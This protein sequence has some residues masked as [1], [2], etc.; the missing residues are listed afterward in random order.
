MAA[1]DQA[2]STAHAQLLQAREE[3]A[4]PPARS[5]QDALLEALRRPYEASALV[6]SSNNSSN[7]SRETSWRRSDLRV[8][9]GRFFP[10]YTQQ[11]AAFAALCAS[12][13]RKDAKAATDRRKESEEQEDEALVTVSF[14][15]LKRVLVR[16]YGSTRLVAKDPFP[17]EPRVEPKPERRASIAPYVPGPT[18]GGTDNGSDDMSAAVLRE[19]QAEVLKKSKS[20]LGRWRARHLLLR[21]G[22]L[23]MHKRSLA[24]RSFRHVHSSGS[25]SGAAA[26]GTSGRAGESS[27]SAFSTASQTPT[28]TAAAA[29]ANTK[30]YDLQDLVSLILE[31][32]S[33]GDSASARKAA[34][35][36]KFRTALT[37]ASNSHSHPSATASQ[38]IKTLVLVGGEASDTLV[39]IRD[40]IATFALYLELSRRDRLPS[41][42]KV[43]RYIAAGAMVNVR[44][45]IPRVS[46]SKESKDGSRR[47]TQAKQPPRGMVT[48][49]QLAFL[50]DPRVPSFESTIA[51]LLNAGADPRSLLYW[52]YATQVVFSPPSSSGHEKKEK[53]EEHR[54]RRRLRKRLLLLDAVESDGDESA[55]FPCCEVQ[56]DDA[57][58]WNLLMYFCWLGDVEGV[59]KLLVVTGAGSASGSGGRTSSRQLVT[60]LD[61]VNAAGDTALH[62]AIKVGK[63]AVALLLVEATLA[64]NAQA[65]HQC[66][67]RGEPVVHLALAARQW[68]VVDALV[69]GGAVDPRS[70]DALGNTALHLAIQLRAPVA[71]IARL[72]QVYRHSSPTGGLDGRAGRRGSNDTPLA[73][74]LKSG[75]QEVVALLLASGASASGWSGQWSQAFVEKRKTRKEE[76]AEEKGVVGEDDRALHVAIKAGM[77]LAAAALIAHKA[78][79]YAVDTRGA[80]SLALAVR[81]G[82]Y[83][84]A[85]ALVDQHQKKQS[86]VA[87]K[88]W[89]VDG[90]T[91]RP[92]VMLALQA[93][94]LELAALLLDCVSQDKDSPRLLH[95]ARVLPLLVQLTSWVETGTDASASAG[96]RWNKSAHARRNSGGSV[97]AGDRKKARSSSSTWTRDRAKSRSDGDWEQLKKEASRRGG[98]DGASGHESPAKSKEDKDAGVFILGGIQALV[99]RFLH[100]CGTTS[101]TEVVGG[102]A[103][104]A[105]VS[106]S[107]LPLVVHLPTTA[108]PSKSSPPTVYKDDEMTAGSPLHVAASGGPFTA[109]LLRLLLAFL[110]NADASAAAKV[111]VRPMGSRAETPLHAALG[112]GAAENALLLLYA[113]REL[114]V[115]SPAVGPVCAQQL[116]MTNLLGDSA[117]HLASAWPH[118][119]AMRLVV[120]LLLQEHVDAGNWN[121]AGL[122]PLHV[123]LREG[124]DD[125]FIEL[126]LRYGQDLNLW[127]EGNTYE[128][129]EGDD[130]ASEYFGTS[131]VRPSALTMVA[132]CPQNP[133]M[134]ALESENAAAFRALVR[135]GAR[136]RAL[137]PRA[138]VGLLQLAVHFNVRDPELLACLL[139]DPELEHSAQSDVADQWGVSPR[140]ARSRLMDVW[141]KERS[142]VE[143]QGAPGAI[144]GTDSEVRQ[145]QRPPPL[146]PASASG[147][148]LPYSLDYSSSVDAPAQLGET[149]VPPPLRIAVPRPPAESVPL[150]TAQYLRALPRPPT[151]SPTTLEYLREEERATLTLVAQEARSEAQDW[152][153]KRIGQKKLLSDAHAQLQSAK[154]HRRTASGSSVSSSSRDDLDVSIPDA[155]GGPVLSDQQLLG[156]L[157]AAAAKKFIDKHVAEAVAEARLAIE[158]EKQTIFQETGL[159]PGMT[160]ASKKHKKK[161]DS[162]HR[163]LLV[164]AASSTTGS[165]LLPASSASVTSVSSEEGNSTQTSEDSYGSASFWWSERGT[166]SFGDDTSLSWLSSSNPRGTTMLSDPA[167]AS[168]SSWAS[169]GRGTML[170]GSLDRRLSFASRS[171]LESDDSGRHGKAESSTD[172]FVDAARQE[173]ESDVAYPNPLDRASFPQVISE[174]NT[175]G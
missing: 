131:G 119:A 8:F 31:H 132:S 73:L 79:I 41:M 85:A 29:A 130:E 26:S 120:E 54:Q 25:S 2:L 42:T 21:W 51:L 74:A 162:R 129:E 123:A 88:P 102:G 28:A 167:S 83:A 107:T 137:M 47:R 7:S 16:Q 34:L 156:E 142:G 117:L 20:W 160:S 44:V 81:Y 144:A 63:E 58:R 115:R 161:G 152:L 111:F 18:S 174:R 86:Q 66:D 65:V 151:L 158:R 60:C 78:D 145:Q 89:W 70:F 150:E 33:D 77:E 128:D 122:A 15:A 37:P 4:Q 112:A 61:H 9:L 140:D 49:L 23:E 113:S 75:Q 32:V 90:E 92:V 68:R 114:Q 125:T 53:S 106:L 69:A 99:V 48:A 67:A 97:D 175:T 62:I 164:R 64:T 46:S 95:P 84:L 82:L 143:A 96:G 12:L 40:H 148:R 59:K 100:L 109:S 101:V 1:L 104:P 43:R 72:I 3:L 168:V 13:A 166:T 173:H 116:E 17:L 14:D 171:F 39:S 118:S 80:S 136:T 124:C 149:R 108:P 57:A 98:N 27:S 11:P 154:K 36:L 159:F 155:G 165:M 172:S 56:A 133:L 170:D 169:N 126:F 55:S 127:T 153:A 38:D 93:G 121:N 141:K 87:G 30:M 139:D 22:V 24:A 35:T 50:Q 110:L 94:Q 147:E 138:R 10:Q 163:S 134:L 91:G 76:S 6:L 103:M 146:H 19:F 5:F 45:R 105:S 71:L 135:G 157:K 52:D